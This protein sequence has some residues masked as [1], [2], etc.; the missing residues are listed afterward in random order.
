MIVLRTLI[1][2]LSIWMTSPKAQAVHLWVVGPENKIYLNTEVDPLLI[3]TQRSVGA[4][5][6]DVF[7]QMRLP[8][9][10]YE[11]GILE[12][13]GLGNLI[14]VDSHQVMRYYGWCYTLNGRLS[15]NMPDQTFVQYPNDQIVWFYGYAMQDDNGNW[16]QCL[17]ANDAIP[18]ERY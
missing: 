4:L 18:N 6:I 5:S 17:P 9:K 2:L 10:G 3:K 16:Q 14:A 7:T 8:F 15:E 1:L 12:I 13:N 11:S